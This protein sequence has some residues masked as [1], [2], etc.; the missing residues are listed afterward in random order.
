MG[1]IFGKETDENSVIMI[2]NLLYTKTDFQ[3]LCVKASNLGILE[4]R[5]IKEL[6]CRHLSWKKKQEL[7]HKSIVSLSLMKK[8]IVKWDKGFF[9]LIQV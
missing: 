3:S 2:L 9:S 8:K 5:V 1:R 4:L 6:L 7:I